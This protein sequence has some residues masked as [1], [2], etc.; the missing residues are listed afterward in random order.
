MSNHCCFVHL[1]LMK[2]YIRT[3]ER[4][5]YK[6]LFFVFLGIKEFPGLWHLLMSLKS[7]E[8]AQ[9]LVTEMA[10]VRVTMSQFAHVLWCSQT[11][12]RGLSLHSPT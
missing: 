8:Q 5:C 3:T 7:T 1:K 4:D 10:L 9:C 6:N 12:V 11:T 2:A